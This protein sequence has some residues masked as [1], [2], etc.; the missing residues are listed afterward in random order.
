MRI[1]TI[2][3][4][5]EPHKGFV[6]KE[7]ELNRDTDTLEVRI[8]EREGSLVACPV[9]GKRCSVYDHRPVR[10]YESVPF[11]HMRVVFLYAP[12]RAARAACGPH[13]EVVPWAEGKSPLTKAYA[14]HLARWAR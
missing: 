5:L 2:L 3:N 10:H 7:C 12:R 6:Y 4:H 11:R 14:W 9:C 1:E 13:A 8:V